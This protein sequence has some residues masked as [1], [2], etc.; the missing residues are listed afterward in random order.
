M[1]TIINITRTNGQLDY[2][3]VL[4]K[5]SLDEYEKNSIKE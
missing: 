2:R 5:I 1:K 4:K 3:R